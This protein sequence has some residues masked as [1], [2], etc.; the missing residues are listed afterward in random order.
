MGEMGSFV[1]FTYESKCWRQDG[2]EKV[3]MDHFGLA[4]WEVE[5]IPHDFLKRSRPWFHTGTK[6]S[7]LYEKVVTN[8]YLACLIFKP[9][10]HLPID[11]FSL[12]KHAD[13]YI[14]IF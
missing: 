1:N 5:K 2:G 12:L 7:H 6:F 11:L 9:F 3:N 10:G 13:I 8:F 4:K 14:Y